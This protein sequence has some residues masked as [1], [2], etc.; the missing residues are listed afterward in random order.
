MSAGSSGTGLTSLAQEI[1]LILMG[2]TRA[3]TEETP[4]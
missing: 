1:G 3:G 4:G 2:T